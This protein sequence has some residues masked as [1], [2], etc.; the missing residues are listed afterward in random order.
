M[1]QLHI[2]KQ[3]NWQCTQKTSIAGRFQSEKIANDSN[4]SH[5]WVLLQLLT[6]AQ[7]FKSLCDIY[8]LI[9]FFL[10]VIWMKLKRLKKSN[11]FNVSKKLMREYSRFTSCR[12]HKKISSQT[13]QPHKK[14]NNIS[15]KINSIL[16]EEIYIFLKS[17]CGSSIIFLWVVNVF[18]NTNLYWIVMRKFCN[19]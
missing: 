10:F 1:Y 5:L 2:L 4:S 3:S 12:S 19:L 18:L 17:E 13:A 11:L 6:R 14:I 16:F 8:R 7:Y 9:F 15:Y